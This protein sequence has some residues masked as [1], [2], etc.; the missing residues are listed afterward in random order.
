VIGL[1]VW[2]E[3]FAMIAVQYDP[4]SAGGFPKLVEMNKTTYETY[5]ESVSL[6]SA[7]TE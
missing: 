5:F 2:D 3:Y 7:E 1:D 6:Q 4:G